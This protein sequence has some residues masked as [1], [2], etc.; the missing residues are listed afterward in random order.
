LLLLREGA[1]RTGLLQALAQC[2]RDY[3]KR[4]AVEHTVE[5][6]IAQR[7][8]GLALGYEGLNDHDCLRDDTL[9]AV[10]VGKRDLHGSD[11]VRQRDRGHALA[12][13]STLNRLEL[14]PADGH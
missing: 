6:L 1:A 11:R 2:F 13:T 10:A 3:R 4:D 7:V 5:D 9:V 14:T 8:Y 12:G